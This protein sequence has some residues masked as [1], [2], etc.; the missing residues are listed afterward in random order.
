V[1][2]AGS[3]SLAQTAAVAVSHAEQGQQAAQQQNMQQQQILK[4]KPATEVLKESSDYPPAP[5]ECNTM[6]FTE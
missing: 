6:E 5:K 3:C 4:P 1:S 2:R